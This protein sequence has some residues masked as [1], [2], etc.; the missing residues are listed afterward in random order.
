MRKGSW[1]RIAT[2]IVW[3]VTIIGLYAQDLFAQDEGQNATTVLR[4]KSDIPKIDLTALAQTSTKI[5][6]ANP[7]IPDA[8]LNK[9]L[10]I[11]KNS[12]PQIENE[13]GAVGLTDNHALWASQK[14]W[15]AARLES[16]LRLTPERAIDNASFIE[17]VTDEIA[18]RIIR[19]QIHQKN[20]SI[21]AYVLDRDLKLIEGALDDIT[22]SYQ[23]GERS[24]VDARNAALF[25]WKTAR[26]ESPLESNQSINIESLKEFTEDLGIVVFI[27]DPDQAEVFMGTESVGTTDKEKKKPYRFFAQDTPHIK[28]LFKK[29]EYVPQEADCEAKLGEIKVC[30][31][32]LKRN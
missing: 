17:H 18:P 9:D 24:S 11:I 4:P 25:A 29:P 15:M 13:F 20:P 26:L 2:F 5:K 30:R 6:N 23:Q 19:W 12:L 10:E 28:V 1:I 21:P 31:V 8:I 22:K 7:D 32:E 27:S 3:S 16:P 14:A